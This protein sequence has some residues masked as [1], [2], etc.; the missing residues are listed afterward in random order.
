MN[1]TEY[2]GICGFNIKS[3]YSNTYK[4]SSHG[5]I[6]VYIPL[7]FLL[8]FFEDYNKILVNCRQELILKRS[9]DDSNVFIWVEP[10]ADGADTTPPKFVLEEVS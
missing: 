8:G 9:K 1:E 5:T 3:P 10:T 7:R 6:E 4:I 2:Y